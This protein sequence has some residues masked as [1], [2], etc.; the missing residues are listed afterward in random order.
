M[1]GNVLLPSRQTHLPKDSVANVSQ[2]VTLD[3][4]VL[5]ERVGRVEGRLLDR[6]LDGIELLIGRGVY[7]P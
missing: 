3:R 5:L 7:S 2:I 6:L 1:P 4:S